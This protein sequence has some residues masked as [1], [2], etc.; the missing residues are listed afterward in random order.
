[1]K[2]HEIS[3]KAAERRDEYRRRLA[4]GESQADIAKT[5]GITRVRVN[6]IVG[7]KDKA[8]ADEQAA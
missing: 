7:R 2:R 1:M 8:K 5:E 4:A 6:Q 3:Q